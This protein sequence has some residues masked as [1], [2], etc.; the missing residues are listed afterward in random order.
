MF[1]ALAIAAALL[2]PMS[3]NADE[4][5][6]IPSTDDAVVIFMA[7]EEMREV[8]KR[9]K[10]GFLKEFYTTPQHKAAHYSELV[11]IAA[12]RHA[13]YACMTRMGLSIQDPDIEEKFIAI[14]PNLRSVTPGASIIVFLFD[15]EK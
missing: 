10:E 7:A 13:R 2:L 14:K 5:S 4:R 1:K 3:A 6:I 8:D 11:H 12:I 15:C 9:F